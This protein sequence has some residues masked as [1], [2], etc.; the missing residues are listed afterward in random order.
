MFRK[1]TVY[2]DQLD[3]K[4]LPPNYDIS[5]N[6]YQGIFSAHLA[7]LRQQMLTS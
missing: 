2:F 1:N 5:P 3:R 7:L 4:N 6:W